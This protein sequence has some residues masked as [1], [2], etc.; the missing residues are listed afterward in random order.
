LPTGRLLARCEQ[1]LH[2]VNDEPDFWA[3]DL[4]GYLE[5]QLNVLAN[6]HCGIPTELQMGQSTEDAIASL[7]RYLERYRSLLEAWP[8][9]FSAAQRLGPDL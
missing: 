2:D 9:L 1:L 6:P 3:R 8:E 7:R 4:R 5:H